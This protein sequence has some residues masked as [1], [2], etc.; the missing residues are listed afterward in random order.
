MFKL[1][2]QNGVAILTA[3]KC[4]HADCTQRFKIIINKNKGIDRKQL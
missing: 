3:S 1:K 4:K 2:W